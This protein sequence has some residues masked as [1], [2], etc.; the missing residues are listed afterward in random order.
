MK[1]LIIIFML[2]VCGN[3]LSAQTD[4]SELRLKQIVQLRFET[5]TDYSKFGERFELSS[6]TRHRGEIVCVSDDIPSVFKIDTNNWVIKSTDLL[7]IGEADM[8]FEAIF[9]DSKNLYLAAET[10]YDA[11]YK[12]TKNGKL[13]KIISVSEFLPVFDKTNSGVEAADIDRKIFYFADEGTKGSSNYI[14]NGAVYQ[15]RNKSA[16]KLVETTGDITDLK[17]IKKNDTT[18]IYILGR[19]NSEIIRYNINTKQVERKS[20]QYIEKS[21][22]YAQALFD[23]GK[24][25]GMGEAL[26][27]TENEIWVGFDNGNERLRTDNQILNKYLK[28]KNSEFP[29]MPIILIFERSF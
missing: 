17:L 18:F 19:N 11:L 12:I 20:Y 28:N 25:Y 15:Y 8:D 7:T 13:K 26:L 27:V 10:G 5:L 14:E 2:F 21:P 29:A 16:Y 1:S 22:K 9:S 6:L 3:R 24:P 4:S 23:T